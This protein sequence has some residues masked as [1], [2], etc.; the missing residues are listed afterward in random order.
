MWATRSWSLTLM[1]Q[2]STAKRLPDFSAMSERTAPEP[3]QLTYSAS[4]STSPRH[5]LTTWVA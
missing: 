5:G 3:K 1:W 2:V 4:P